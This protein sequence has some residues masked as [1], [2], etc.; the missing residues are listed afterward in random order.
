MILSIAFLFLYGG[1]SNIG[2]TPMGSKRM[3]SPGKCRS[4]KAGSLKK[5]VFQRRRMCLNPELI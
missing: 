3:A 2:N 5:G 1:L 4:R